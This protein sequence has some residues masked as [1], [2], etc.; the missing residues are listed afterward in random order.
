[1]VKNP[2][3]AGLQLVIG[4]DAN[5]KSDQDVEDLKA[6]LESLGLTA[7]SVGPTTIKQRMV[8]AQH[9]KSGRF[10]VD[11]EDYLITLKPEHGGAF[12]LTHETVG[13]KEEKANIEVPLPNISNPSDHY[14]VGATLQANFR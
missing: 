14:P 3:N 7:T 10:A 12:L 5:T 13:F 6:H 2:E 11:E 9:S 8:T 1:M 4:I